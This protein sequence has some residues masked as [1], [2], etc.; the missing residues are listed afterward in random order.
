MHDRWQALDD[1]RRGKSAAPLREIKLIP[2]DKIELDD[3]AEYLVHGLIPRDGLTV[4]WG[5]PKCS[6]SFIIYDLMMHVALD[7][8][9]RGRHVEQG[10]VVYCAFEG[11][12]GFKKRCAAFKCR[13]LKGHTEP[14]PFYLQPLRLDMITD[15]DASVEAIK[16]QLGDVVPSAITLD[17]LN[18]SLVGSESSD[19]DMSAYVAA[20]DKLREAFNCSVIIVHHCGIVGTRPRGHTSLIGAADAQLAI[21]RSGEISTLT[22][23]FMKD[24]E[25]GEVL[26]FKLETVTVDVDRYSVPITSCVVVPAEVEAITATT[27]KLTKN[28]QTMFSILHSAKRLTTDEWNEQARVLA[29]P[30]T[31]ICTTTE[32]RSRVRSW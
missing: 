25:E 12:R 9:Y 30:A 10:A 19:E 5:P 27:V 29:K 13:F 7:W 6:K 16:E 11:G 18:R 28:Q 4:A 26:A 3:N 8:Q 15:A 32:R 14:V 21:A 31:R 24:G 23:E 2:F 1:E 20:A 17:T 22:V